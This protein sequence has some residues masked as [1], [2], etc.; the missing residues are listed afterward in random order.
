[1]CVAGR[2]FEPALLLGE[3]RQERDLE[4]RTLIG[5]ICIVELNYERHNAAE[6]TNS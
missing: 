4:V 2:L 6:T 1:M 3:V 5:L